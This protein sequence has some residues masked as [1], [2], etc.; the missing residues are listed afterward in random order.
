MSD[1]IN[2]LPFSLSFF[3]KNAF[4]Y[5]Q[6][7]NNSSILPIPSDA[8]KKTTK[9]AY[10]AGFGEQHFIFPAIYYY[11]SEAGILIIFV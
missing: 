4:D 2:I 8:V 9:S 3:R 5:L 11:L 1:S 10:S 6:I 7:S